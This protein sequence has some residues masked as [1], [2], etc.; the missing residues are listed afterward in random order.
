MKRQVQETDIRKWFGSDWI[1]LQEETFEVI[2][3]HYEQYGNMIIKGCEIV[4]GDADINPGIV[5]LHGKDDLNNDIYKVARF[6]GLQAVVSFPVYLV[7]TKTEEK[8][9]YNTGTQ[10]NVSITYKAT[11][12]YSLPVGEYLIINQD[13]NNKT[14]RD[15]IQNSGYRFVT[16]AEKSV[17]GAARSGAVADVQGG[18]A[19]DKNTLKKLFD[20]LTLNNLFSGDGDTKLHTTKKVGIGTNNPSEKL[21][22]VD[23]RIKTTGDSFAD[24]ASISF[25]NY[26]N[27]NLNPSVIGQRVYT[28][29]KVGI[30]I[31]DGTNDSMFIGND[32][33]IGIGTNEPNSKLDVI[34]SDTSPI[35][36]FSLSSNPNSAGM[37]IVSSADLK[38]FIFQTEYSGVLDDAFSINRQY[39]NIGIGTSSPDARVDIKAPKVTLHTMKIGRLAGQGSIKASGIDEPSKYLM[40]ESTGESIGLN[41]FSTDNVVLCNGGGN[42]GIG[43]TAPTSKLEVSGNI[44]CTDVIIA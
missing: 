24:G 3:G 6:E 36:R 19:T 28:S 23:G 14:Y 10:K 5:G 40:F 13:G 26:G 17:W 8:R 39:A 12:Q 32:G 31:G 25:H 35:F 20:V 9:L 44:K 4:N 21:E 30:G 11:P 42:V 29:E 2:D 33:K 22:I 37:Q 1:S 18:I 38:T 27:S 41:W 16:D 43:I 15:A 34:F 7:L